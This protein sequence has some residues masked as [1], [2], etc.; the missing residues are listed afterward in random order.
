MVT[1]PR[2]SSVKQRAGRGLDLLLA[3]ALVLGCASAGPRWENERKAG[4]R[5]LEKGDVEAAHQRYEAALQAAV[6]AGSDHLPGHEQ[7]GRAL[8]DVSRARP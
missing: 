1:Q 7:P 2:R 8:H 6:S 4:D 3:F 5:L